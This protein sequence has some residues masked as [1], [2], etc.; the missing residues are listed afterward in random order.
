[1]EDDLRKEGEASWHVISYDFLE[2]RE[3]WMR[4]VIERMDFPVDYREGYLI[5]QKSVIYAARLSG[6]GEQKQCG[7]CETC[8]GRMNCPKKKNGSSSKELL[9]GYM[10]ILGGK[11]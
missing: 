9:Y 5:P 8:T 2:G 3:K 7:I 11:R 6:N 1:M 10:R 4:E